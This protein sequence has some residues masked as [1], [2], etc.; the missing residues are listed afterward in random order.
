MT[1]T[2]NQNTNGPCPQYTFNP[3]NYQITTSGFT[4]DA[5]G[6]LTSDGSN[7]YQYNAEGRIVNVL[8][9][10]NTYSTSTYNAFE[11]VVETIYP[12]YNVTVDGLFD[13]AGR[14]IGYIHSLSALASFCIIGMAAYALISFAIAVD[15]RERDDIVAHIFQ[16]VRFRRRV[17][18]G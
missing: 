3:L 10:G 13:P 8:E 11:Q 12:G 6:D 14:E 1:C 18:D 17:L 15:R 2:Q 5:A 4:Y 16:L 9:A 7:T